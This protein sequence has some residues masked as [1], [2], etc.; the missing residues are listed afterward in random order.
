MDQVQ[1]I[2]ML[3]GLNE[4]ANQH[5][6]AVQWS[7]SICGLRLIR[8]N[9]L[10]CNNESPIRGTISILTQKDN[11]L[12]VECAFVAGQIYEVIINYKSKLI[13]V[14]LFSKR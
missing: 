13:S 14:I 8:L 1:S 7:L 3:L 2:L 4:N 9:K 11:L 12:F 10:V 6:K 5:C